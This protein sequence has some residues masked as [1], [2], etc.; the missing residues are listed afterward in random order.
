MRNCEISNML[1]IWIPFLRFLE[2][3]ECPIFFGRNRKQA[4]TS[5]PFIF[6]ASTRE[7]D[8]Q[9]CLAVCRSTWRFSRWPKCSKACEIFNP[10][11][12]VRIKG[13]W[14][15]RSFLSKDIAKNIILARTRALIGPPLLS[16]IW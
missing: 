8:D 16:N 13:S 10:K 12:Y 1:A 6:P 14:K 9:V 5:D 11:I 3:K 2:M 7:R 4:R 15:A